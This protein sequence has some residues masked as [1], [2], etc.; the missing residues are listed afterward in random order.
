MKLAKVLF[1]WRK[2]T[3]P[4]STAL[5][6]VET[7]VAEPIAEGMKAESGSSKRVE[8]PPTFDPSDYEDGGSP[9]L[10]CTITLLS[11]VLIV[12]VVAALEPYVALIAN[13]NG[14]CRTVAV[15]LVALAG[16][17]IIVALAVFFVQYVRLPRYVR[18]SRQEFKGREETL[19]KKLRRRHLQGLGND[20]R[21]LKERIGEAAT[22]KVLEL[23]NEDCAPS[24][25]LA[26]FE[27]YQCE[28]DGWA[29]KEVSRFAKRIGFITSAVRSRR[30]DV[31][32]VVV[33]SSAM[34]LRLARI[35]NQRMSGYSALRLALRFVLNVYVAGQAQGCL[36]AVAKGMGRIIGVGA[37]VV[38]TAA[39]HPE[40]APAVAGGVEAMS[41]AMGAGAE[42][43]VNA[44]L[45]KKLGGFARVQLHVLVD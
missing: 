27:A 36:G 10:T 12:W 23:A 16:V 39:G 1:F 44:L 41:G 15:C 11:V 5:V 45:A 4:V 42:F 17:A 18:F 9:V 30:G 13:S 25:W 38:T 3:L 34:I 33:L 20:A 7:A 22:E 35:Y 31:A 8:E 26:K 21:L 43:A 2:E 32:T 19:V 14:N 40:M 24:E 29:D 37:A 6:R 28:L